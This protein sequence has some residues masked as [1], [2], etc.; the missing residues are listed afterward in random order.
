MGAIAARLRRMGGTVFAC[1]LLCLTIAPVVDSLFCASE[2][3]AAERVS[4]PACDQASVV[5]HDHGDKGHP[6]S[7]DACVHGHCHQTQ[8]PAAP[9]DVQWADTST[10]AVDLTPAETGLPPSRAPDGP[11]EPPRA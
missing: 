9:V 3:S 2:A 4:S 1:L 6:D 10:S 5:A 7:G 11:M 8:A